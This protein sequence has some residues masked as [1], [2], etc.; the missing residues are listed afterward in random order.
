MAKLHNEILI[1]A[2]IDKIWEALTVV[3]KLDTYDPTVKKSTAITGLRSGV[4]AKRKVDMLDGKNWFEE[5][6]TVSKSN[7]ALTYELTACSFPVQKLKHSYSFHK[8]GN[9]IRVE[10]EMNYKM[11]FGFLG[12]IMGAMFKPKWNKGI[13]EFL[14]GLKQYAEA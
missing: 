11:K 9:E 13:N 1:D 8:V 12:N 6:C 10:Q 3:D 4:G 14:G 7:E 2:S 5:M